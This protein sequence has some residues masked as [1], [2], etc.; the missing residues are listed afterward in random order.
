MQAT[1]EKV[2]ALERRLKVSLPAQEIDGEVQNRL[3]RLA[4]NVRM[5]GFRPGK[6][7]FRLVQKQ[8]GGQVRQ[9]VLGDALQKTFGEAVKQQNLRV[10]GYPRFEAA[11][12][13]SSGDFEFSATFEVYPEIQLTALDSAVIERPNVAADEV[14][15]DKTVEV[16]RKQRVTYRAV[17]RGTQTGDRITLDYRGTQDG[18][19]FE[20]GSGTDHVTILG[21]GRLLADFEKQVVGLKAGDSRAFELTFP[22]DYHGK[23]LAGKTAHFDVTVKR[24]EEAVLPEVDADFAKQLGVSDGDIAKM[25]ADVKAN[26]E[27]EVRRRVQGRL[28]DQVMKV[29]LSSATLELPKALVEL[30]IERLQAGMRKDLA[31]RG[32]KPDEIPMPRDAFEPEARRRVSLG[33]IV[34][35]VVKQNSLQAKPDQVKAVIQDYAQSYEKPEEVVRWYYQSP[36]RLREAESLVLE[37]NV[38]QW[39]LSQAKVEE[40]ATDFDELMGN[41]K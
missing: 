7:P 10:A 35:E 15:V 37:D 1:I 16:L 28:K 4:R 5:H 32:L 17:E 23:E 19:A 29:L 14:A 6:V 33:L 22:E 30:E 11:P 21:E 9:E 13:E 36:E 31:D 18:Q 20:G 34:A 27:R 24:V 3:L 26:L 38:V 39:A 41:A 40:K 8:Y 12:T 25:R 2:S